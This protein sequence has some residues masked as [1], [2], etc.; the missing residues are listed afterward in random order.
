MASNEHCYIITSCV[1]RDF[2]NVKPP[3]THYV[4][5]LAAVLDNGPH[6][7]KT[8]LIIKNSA[9]CTVSEDR[10]NN[11]VLICIHKRGETN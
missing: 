8:A 6:T 4:K 7:V 5:F 9:P 11:D 1:N 10:L 2:S 3:V